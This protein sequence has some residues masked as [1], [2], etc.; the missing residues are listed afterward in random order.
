MEIVKQYNVSKKDIINAKAS[1]KSF[2]EMS[3]YVAVKAAYISNE[4]DEKTGEA[5]QVSGII[6]EDGTI[7]AG[8]SASILKQVDDLIDLLAEGESAECITNVSKSNN[9]RE[10]FSLMIH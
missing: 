8:K 7:Y 1:S 10:F 9:G 4:V 5:M 2:K 6:A 3:D